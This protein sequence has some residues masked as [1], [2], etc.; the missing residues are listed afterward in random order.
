MASAVLEIK[1]A[2][3]VVGTV[4]AL[5]EGEM[6]ALLLGRT[7]ILLQ[8]TLNTPL[9]LSIYCSFDRFRDKTESASTSTVIAPSVTSRWKIANPHNGENSP[10]AYQKVRHT[11]MTTSPWRPCRIITRNHRR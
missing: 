11:P 2:K 7:R 4:N 6:D 1:P 8:T 9:K 5:P 10:D 3:S